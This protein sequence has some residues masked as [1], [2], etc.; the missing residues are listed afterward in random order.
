MALDEALLQ[1][2]RDGSR[3]LWGGVWRRA[4]LY[5]ILFL[6]LIHAGFYGA[7]WLLGDAW[8]AGAH[9]EVAIAT[10]RLLLPVAALLAACFMALRDSLY[11]LVVPGPLLRSLGD[12]VLSPRVRTGAL[13]PEG[14][15]A[16]FASPQRLAHAARMR[17]LPLILFLTRIIL[18][19]D[20]KSLLQTAEAGVGREALVREVE[21]QARNRVALVLR[22]LA[23]LVWVGLGCALPLPFLVGWLFW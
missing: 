4:G 14:E 3:D 15:F 17:E 16:S 7:L 22:Y 10:A 2:I 21:R 13:S 18:R 1:R 8:R 9:R 12:L 19:V 5:A 20:V 23:G 6:L 11:A